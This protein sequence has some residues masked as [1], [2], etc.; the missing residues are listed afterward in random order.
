[1]EKFH[2]TGSVSKEQYPRNRAW[3][4]LTEPAQLLILNSIV[5]KPGVHLEEIKKELISVLMVE[6]E[7]STIM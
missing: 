6:V 4:K 7:T 2:A 5:T 1:L 3:R